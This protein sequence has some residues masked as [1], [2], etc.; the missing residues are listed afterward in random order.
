MS[1]LT[2]V[3]ACLGKPLATGLDF[4][5]LWYLSIL[6]WT[7]L[8]VQL[9]A[10]LILNTTDKEGSLQFS[11]SGK[12]VIEISKRHARVWQFTEMLFQDRR[13]HQSQQLMNHCVSQSSLHLL[14]F[15]SICSISLPTG[16]KYELFSFSERWTLD[17]SILEQGICRLAHLG[18]QEVLYNL[19]LGACLAAREQL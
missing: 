4:N 14:L 8:A 2:T 17:Q 12:S 5:S 16:Q 18:R 15:P 1:S 6:S 7:S 10:S 11:H 9:S 19:T 3:T 13:L